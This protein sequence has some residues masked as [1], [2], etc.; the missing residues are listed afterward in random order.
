M[1]HD[2]PIIQLRQLSNYGQSCFRHISI[3]FIPTSLSSL[4]ILKQIIDSILF[5]LQVFQPVSL[6]CEDALKITAKSLSFN[7]HIPSF[8]FI[9]LLLQFCLFFKE[10]GLLGY[11]S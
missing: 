8:L 10:T 9:Y 2:V 4:D 5:H 11:L 1:N 7:L 6:K 3:P